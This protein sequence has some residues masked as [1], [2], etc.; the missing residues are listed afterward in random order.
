MKTLNEASVGSGENTL[1]IGS[2]PVV[3]TTLRFR[4]R[5]NT[6]RQNS[7]FRAE[8]FEL[9]VSSLPSTLRPQVQTAGRPGRHRIVRKRRAGS[10]IGFKLD[11]SQLMASQ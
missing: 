10:I 4:T 9:P 8:P 6:V 1:L 11:L 3:G 7:A 2:S 5:R